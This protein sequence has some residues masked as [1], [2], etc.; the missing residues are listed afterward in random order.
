MTIYR[1]RC[2]GLTVASSLTDGD[3]LIETALI[4]GLAGSAEQRI[5]TAIRSP[6]LPRTGDV[7]HAFPWLSCQ[8]IQADIHPQDGTIALVT[9]EWRSA[10]AGDGGFLPEDTPPV[11]EVSVTVESKQTNYGVNRRPL[12]VSYDLEDPE[13]GTTSEDEQIA[14]IEI[15][16]PHIVIVYRRRERI[17]P[18]IRALGYIGKVNANFMFGDAARFWLCTNLSGESP[19]AGGSW[20]VTYGFER[21][22]ESWDATVAYHLNGEIPGDVVDGQGIRTYQVYPEANF[23]ELGLPFIP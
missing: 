7:H 21:N 1:P 6:Q 19:D 22:A 10:A 23:A 16:V 3:R 13:T 17:S 4:T 15:F 9:I 18:G 2:E 20:N 14:T 5:Q 11:L 12:L 8:S